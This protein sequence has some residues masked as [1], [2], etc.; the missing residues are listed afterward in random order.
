MGFHLVLL[1]YTGF[2][3]V[4]LGFTGF[5]WVL[6]GFTGFYLVL[7]SVN[8]CLKRVS[9]GHFFSS[10]KF[11]NK[12]PPKNE[13]EKIRFLSNVPSLDG[14]RC[15]VIFLIVNRKPKKKRK[16]KRN[17]WGTGQGS[18]FLLP[19]RETGIVIDSNSIID[20][21]VDY[22][23]SFFNNENNNK[24]LKKDASIERIWL[25]NQKKRK[26]EKKKEVAP[27]WLMMT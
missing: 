25:E 22:R 8:I 4:L 18:V 17:R 13:R 20:W 5:Y 15:R 19:N 23:L 2:Y 9:T 21:R 24:Y 7:P 14:G 16:R 1:G 27:D 11:P 6:L 10:E 26:N 3:W 12:N